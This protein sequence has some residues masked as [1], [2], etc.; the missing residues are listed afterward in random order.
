MNTNENLIE[1]LNDLVQINN[2]R[3]TGYEKAIAESKDEDVD[4]K[5]LF[6]S[7]VNES[8]QYVSELRSKITSLGG[9]AT[10]DTTTSGK[11]YRAWMDVKAVF[12]GSDRK[13]LLNSCEFGED[14][15]QKAY[16]TAL[17]SDSEID[18]DTRQLIM[19]QKTALKK[20]HDMI[21]KYRDL[22]GGIA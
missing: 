4:L 6:R 19:D 13:A 17:S 5:G 8:G 16:D 7:M 21:K 22:Q 18:A 14:A 20:S 2:D 12:T 10:D 1:V 11:I 15:A 9:T 3:I